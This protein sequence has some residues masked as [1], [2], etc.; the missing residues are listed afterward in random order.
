MVNAIRKLGP[1][2][3]APTSY[4]PTLYELSETFLQRE[5][6]ETNATLD[7]F[8]WSYQTNSCSLMTNTWSG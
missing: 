2:L 4:T 7:S 8:K 6:D 3:Q 5:V 1:N